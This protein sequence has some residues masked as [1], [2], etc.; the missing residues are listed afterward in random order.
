M[1]HLLILN[2]CLHSNH[3]KTTTLTTTHRTTTATSTIQTTIGIHPTMIMDLNNTKEDGIVM[4]TKTS[5]DKI[6]MII[7]SQS[8]K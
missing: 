8:I 6:I 2:Q 4:V 3:L 7:V 1:C 5:E